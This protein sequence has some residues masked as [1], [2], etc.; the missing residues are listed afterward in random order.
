MNPDWH[1]PFVLGRLAGLN[2][3]PYA[4]VDAAGVSPALRSFVASRLAWIDQLTGLAFVESATPAISIIRG[5]LPEGAPSDGLSRVSDT[6][7]SVYVTADPIGN[8]AQYVLVHEL[9]H[10]LGLTHPQGDGMN[11]AFPNAATIMSGWKEPWQ[12]YRTWLSPLDIANLQAVHGPGDPITGTGGP[13]RLNGTAGPDVITGGGGTDRLRGRGGEDLL[14]GGGG[15]D[16]FVIEPGGVALVDD[17]GKRDRVLW[18]GPGELTL[19]R[20]GADHQLLH[21]GVLVAE[22]PRTPWFTL[23]HIL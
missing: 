3:I 14:Y 22:L 7:N 20:Q 16:Q 15:R 5:P 4:I 6:E 1:Q 2:P 10:A 18:R 17:F 12:I 8:R 13:D 21:R 11:A 9:A 23:D 19:Y